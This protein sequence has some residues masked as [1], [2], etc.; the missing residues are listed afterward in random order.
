MSTRTSWGLK[1]KKSVQALVLWG[2]GGGGGVEGRTFQ[3]LSPLREGM[4]FFARKGGV[5][6]EMEGV[7]TFF[8]VLLL[9]LITF[10]FLH[11]SLLS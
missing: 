4:K 5:G 10:T 3:K 11:F 7:V 6:V 8:T 9:S 1:G 2:G